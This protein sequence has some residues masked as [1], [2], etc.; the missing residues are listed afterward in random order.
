MALTCTK[1]HLKKK[2]RENKH[3]MKASYRD[4]LAE[5]SF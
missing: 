4:V 5:A 2:K 3:S 1:E